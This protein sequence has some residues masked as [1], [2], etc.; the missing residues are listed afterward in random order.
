MSEKKI[1]IIKV[2][3]DKEP[4]EFEKLSEEEGYFKLIKEGA[5]YINNEG[6][7]SEIDLRSRVEPWLSSLFQSEHLSL[8]LGSGLSTAIQSLQSL[9]IQIFPRKSLESQELPF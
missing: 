1:N 5:S 7:F 2:R 8:L 6:K 4:V 3:E 9:R